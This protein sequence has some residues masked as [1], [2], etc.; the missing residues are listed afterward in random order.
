MGITTPMNIN[1]KHIAEFVLFYL[2]GLLN[3]ELEFCTGHEMCS[4]CDAPANH[5]NCTVTDMVQ[6]IVSSL[7]GCV[8][9]LKRY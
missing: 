7:L 2:Y 9:V 1:T 6:V 8:D 5:N 3:I 4:E